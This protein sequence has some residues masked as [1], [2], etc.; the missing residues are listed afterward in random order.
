MRW[1]KAG[2]GNTVYLTYKLSVLRPFSVTPGF[3]FLTTT[4]LRSIA[5]TS[6]A[7][8]LW[9]FLHRHVTE[10][11]VLLLRPLEG[12]G[13]L[14]VSRAR[15]WGVAWAFVTYSLA[16]T[17]CKNT[18]DL[19]VRC[20]AIKCIFASFSPP[21]CTNTPQAHRISLHSKLVAYCN[22]TTDL[23]NC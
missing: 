4:I 16:K 10:Q 6:W 8:T 9:H 3:R 12:M 5:F 11:S 7:T 22:R 15:I 13:H 14:I 18:V 2:E 17:P 19:N 1:E 20:S 21:A 23:T